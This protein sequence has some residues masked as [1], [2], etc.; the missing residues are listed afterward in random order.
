LGH[1]DTELKKDGVVLAAEV[2][3]VFDVK[4]DVQ[5]ARWSATLTRLSLGSQP[6]AGPMVDTRRNLDGDRALNLDGLAT[7]A[8]G[9]WRRND[10]ALT[11][12]ARACG[13]L[14]EGSQEGLLLAANLTRSATL[15]AA[16]GLRTRFSSAPLTVGARFVPK[17]G[18]LVLAA[19]D[20]F[21]KV[22]GE[23]VA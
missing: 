4:N 13:H 10:L 18:N 23:I 9:A 1:V 7:A 20:S 3:M 2:G 14:Y 19:K 6:D 22:D 8:A 11:L 15:G 5:I 16:D 17:D 12:T 21:L